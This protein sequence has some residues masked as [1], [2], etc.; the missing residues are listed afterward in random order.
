[1]ASSPNYC[2]RSR[3]YNT[4]RKVHKV[5]SCVRFSIQAESCLVSLSAVALPSYASI[6]PWQPL[7]MQSSQQTAFTIPREKLSQSEELNY[8]PQFSLFQATQ[9]KLRGGRELTI[10]VPLQSQIELDQILQLASGREHCQLISNSVGSFNKTPGSQR[11]LTHFCHIRQQD[12]LVFP[13]VCVCS[14]A[15]EWS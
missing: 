14:I 5:A 3:H 2:N 1:M 8:P 12:Y 4:K 13:V 15:W 11:F 9:L 6:S 10:W 7:P